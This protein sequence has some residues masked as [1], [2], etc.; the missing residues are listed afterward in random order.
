MFEYFVLL[1]VHV[2]NGRYLRFKKVNAKV[3]PTL[4]S[5]VNPVKAPI[6]I[7]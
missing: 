2:S 1:S 4:N 7:Q 3:K 6:D 5:T